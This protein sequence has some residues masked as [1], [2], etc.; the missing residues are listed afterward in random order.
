MN[1]AYYYDN[2]TCWLNQ[3]VNYELQWAGEGDLNKLLSITIKFN[4]GINK[5]NKYL[6]QRI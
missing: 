5:V 3:L 2:G 6:V 1:I 4:F